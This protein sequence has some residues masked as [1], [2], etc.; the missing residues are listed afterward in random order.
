MILLRKIA[1]ALAGQAVCALCA[2]PAS[3]AMVLGYQ[4]VG[5]GTITSTGTVNAFTVPGSNF[6]GDTFAGPTGQIG[7][8]PAG[9]G[10]YDD[11]LFSIPTGASADSITSTINLGN[12]LAI[13][14]LDVRLYSITGNPVLPVLGTPVGTVIDGTLTNLG[15][16]GMVDSLTATLAAGT[17]VLEVRGNVTGPSGGSYSGTLNVAPVP[18]PAALPLLLCGLGLFR[19]I[20]RPYR[21]SPVSPAFLIRCQGS[22]GRPEAS[23]RERRAKASGRGPPSGSPPLTKRQS[24]D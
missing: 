14:N 20:G 7:G 16:A 19:W 2:A 5:P 17:Y 13:G 11:F 21:A 24:S 4:E 1:V 12:V 23:T 15:G 8:A 3:A 9:F 10:F 6:Y 18:L 22:R